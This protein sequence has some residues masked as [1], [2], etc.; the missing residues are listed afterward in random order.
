[1]H[2]VRARNPDIIKER[3]RARYIANCE[4]IKD[5]SRRYRA[6]NKEFLSQKA[7]ERAQRAREMGIKRKR[8]GSR[9]SSILAPK[10][11]TEVIQQ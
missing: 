4:K 10:P 1:M 6:C 11:S 9:R 5:Q 2:R 7:K 3:N 8:Y